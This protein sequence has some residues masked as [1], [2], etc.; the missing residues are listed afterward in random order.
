VELTLL[1]RTD[2]FW[3]SLTCSTA[4]VGRLFFFLKKKEKKK[5]NGIGVVVIREV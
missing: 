4:V 2:R 5:E 3:Q 1:S